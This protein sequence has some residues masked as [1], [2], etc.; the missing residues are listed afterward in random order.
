M[1]M[2]SHRLTPAMAVLLFF[3]GC[4]LPGRIPDKDGFRLLEEKA[5]AGDPDSQYQLGLQYTIDGKWAWHSARGYGWFAAAAVNG[6]ADAQYMAGMGKLLGRGTL[7]DEEGAVEMFRLAAQQGHER[8]QYQLGLAYLNGRGVIKD[9]PWGRQWLEQA[10]WNGHTQ[11]QFLLGALFAKGVGG[12]CNLA[13]AW[14]WLEKSRLSGQAQSATAVKKLEERMS[15][16]DLDAGKLLFAQQPRIDKDGFYAN[17]RLRYVQTMLN[18]IGYQAG[19]EDGLPGPRTDASMAAFL[20]A[21]K[22]PR[23]TQI[24]QLVESLRG[25]Y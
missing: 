3:S 19:I 7:Y 6:H 20:R 2:F 24:M 23:E 5:Y 11:A 17:P 1:E 9:R 8:A 16:S 15:A 22:L 4:S 12:Q 13:E 21:K 10:A 18:R 14:R 25:E